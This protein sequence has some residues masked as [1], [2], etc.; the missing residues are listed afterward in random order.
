MMPEERAAIVAWQL[1]APGAS[2]KRFK[3][4]LE[5]Q[6]HP[7]RNRAVR[8]ISDTTCDAEVEV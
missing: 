1:L 6:I 8:L 3:R 2:I 4:Q 7:E 5:Q